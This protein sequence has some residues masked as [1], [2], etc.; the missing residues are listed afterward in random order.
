[1]HPPSRTLVVASRVAASPPWALDLPPATT[2]AYWAH[3]R[4]SDA[5]VDELATALAP[6]GL[7]HDATARRPALRFLAR[8]ASGV[9]VLVATAFFSVGAPPAVWHLL[10]EHGATRL[11]SAAPFQPHPTVRVWVARRDA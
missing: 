4:P 6:L 1:M 5:C 8:D 11:Y 10:V 7:W 3:V 2:Q 9:P